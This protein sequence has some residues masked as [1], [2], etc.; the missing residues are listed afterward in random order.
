LKPTHIHWRERN[1]CGREKAAISSDKRS[2]L[3]LCQVCSGVFRWMQSCQVISS[4]AMENGQVFHHSFA[5]AWQRNSTHA[6]RGLGF[7]NKLE[8]RKVRI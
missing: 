3:G 2:L 6:L 7:L 8:Q 4:K 1:D 5:F